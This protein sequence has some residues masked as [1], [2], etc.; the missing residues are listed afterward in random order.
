[1][2]NYFL[3][4][5]TTQNTTEGYFNMKTCYQYRVEYMQNLLAKEV[6]LTKKRILKKKQL[7][8]WIKIL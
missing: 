1:P 2:N 7:N 8:T 4:K 3:F 6:Y 5:Y